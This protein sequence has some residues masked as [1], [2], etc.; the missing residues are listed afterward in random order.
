MVIHSLIMEIINFKYYLLYF[1][2]FKYY[3]DYFAL[4]V[5]LCLCTLR[6]FWIMFLLFN[7][8]QTHKNQ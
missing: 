1:K 8:L 6:V 4:D 5:V 3:N 7:L 2:Y